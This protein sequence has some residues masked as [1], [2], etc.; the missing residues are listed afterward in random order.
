[1][2]GACLQAMSE[3][4]PGKIACKQAPTPENQTVIP[5]FEQK[6]IPTA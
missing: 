3:V 5:T 2:V 4:C 6:L 1:M